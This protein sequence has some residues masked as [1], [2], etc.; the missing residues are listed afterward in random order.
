[1]RCCCLTKRCT[2]KKSNLARVAIRDKVT[3]HLGTDKLLPGMDHV[4][5]GLSLKGVNHLF[6]KPQSLKTLTIRNSSTNL[7]LVGYAKGIFES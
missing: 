4:M 5:L 3:V 6:S 2:S 7:T 1:M